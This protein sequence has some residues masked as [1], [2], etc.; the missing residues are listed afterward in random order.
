MR[1]HFP[2]LLLFLFGCS[3]PPTKPP[4]PAA[5]TSEDQRFAIRNQGYSLL[6]QLLSDEANVSKLLIIKK[7]SADLGALIKDIS[8]IS[9]DRAKQIEAFSK[10]DSHLHIK[11]TSLPVVEQQTRD[12]IAKSKAKE[13]ISKTGEKFEVRIVLAQAE[14]LSYGAHMAAAI[15]PNENNPERKKLLA[16]I[17]EDYQQLHQRLIDLIHS[18]WRAAPAS[19]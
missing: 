13:L 15:I 18:R 7:E 11:M 5:V 8:R 3:T 6:F 19:R 1:I 9:A 2:L 17:S 12:L 14:A 10:T 4:P 16:R